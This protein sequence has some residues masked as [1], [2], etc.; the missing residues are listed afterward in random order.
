MI[1]INSISG[2]KTS[3]EIFRRYDADYN[4]FAIVRTNDKDC[5]WMKGKD[6][7]TRQEI[8]DRIGMDF[9]GTLEEDV[10]IYTILDLEQKFGKPINIL[11]A[12][13]SYEEMIDQHGLN[14]LPSPLRRYCTVELKLIPQFEWWKKNINEVVEMRIGYRANE[15][16]R[17][18]RM[19][20]RCDS[21]RVLS[22]KT[23]VGSKETKGGTRNIW[24]EIPWQKPV[25][26]FIEWEPTF[27]DQ[28]DAGWKNENVRFA[29]YNNCVG[30]FNR[31]ELLLR[32]YFEKEPEK[33]DVFL[34]F[35]KNRK[36][37]GDTLKV[38]G[39]TYER[40]KRML[41]N[42]KMASEDL[43]SCDSGFCGL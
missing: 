27:K 17:M 9:W 5:L 37:N 23:V 8:S 41:P 1:T 32:Y 25:F 24:K 30:C 38:N 36:Y 16:S 13:Y 12:S 40:I 35:E 11:T 18:K 2:G 34:G 14:F 6:E 33:M 10:I 15:M 4:N 7:K 28:I 19:L 21:N 29:E 26:P 43:G 20:K 42:Y 3:S 31:D 39:S 22:H